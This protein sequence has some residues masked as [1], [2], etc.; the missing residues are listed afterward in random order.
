MVIIETSVFTRQVLSLLTDEEYRQF[1]HALAA[2]PRA[3][4]VI[5]GG[6]G[7]RKIRWATRG[8]GKSG[9]VRVIYFWAE[10]RDQLFMLLIY[11]KSDMGDLTREQIKKL[12]QIIEA[13]VP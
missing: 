2:E 8:H 1:Q 7:L 13:Q 4:S 3:G 11:S 5:K 10:S 6:G 12:R 9:G